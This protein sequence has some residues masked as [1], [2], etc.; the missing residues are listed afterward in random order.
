M[1]PATPPID[2]QPLI[3]AARRVRERAYAPYSRFLVGA[4]VL[5]A[6]GSIHAGCNVEN[7]TFGV[8]VCAER[9]ALTGAVAAGAG[10]PRAL[11]VITACDP[12]APP[13]GL[14]L[15]TMAELADPGLPI[16]LCNL[17]GARIERCLED[18]LPYPFRMPAESPATRDGE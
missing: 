13:C 16:L 4:A 14:C 17:D 12:P 7:R 11:A 3:E 6:G 8:T 10:R 2:W 18:F 1:S 5:G 9:V 15:E